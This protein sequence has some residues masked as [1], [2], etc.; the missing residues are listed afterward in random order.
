M[1]CPACKTEYKC[2]CP[3]C[4]EHCPSQWKMVDMQED[5]EDWNEVCPG[6]GKSE[7]VHWWFDEE[8]RQYEK[9]NQNFKRG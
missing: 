7:S 2:P 8:F 4:N 9:S 3:S 5:G 6:C 1:I